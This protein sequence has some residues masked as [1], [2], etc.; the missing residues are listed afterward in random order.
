MPNVLIRDLPTAVHATL[1]ARAS[2][3]GMSMQQYLSAQLCQL[4]RT[5]TMAEVLDR[6]D[7]HPDRS[8]RV[9]PDRV[10]ADLDAQRAERDRR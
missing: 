8:G 4:A 1:Q 9:D 6:I 5:P 2:A 10:V 7:S 3:A